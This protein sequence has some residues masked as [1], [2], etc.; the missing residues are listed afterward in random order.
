MR[1]H[2]TKGTIDLSTLP[3]GTYKIYHE[4][5][6]NGY[7]QREELKFYNDLAS[8]IVKVKQYS[9]SK[10]NGSSLMMTKEDSLTR[11][12]IGRLDSMTWN[13]GKLKV[14]GYGELAGLSMSSA[15]DV[16]H[17]LIIENWSSSWKQYSYTLTPKYSSWLAND[18]HNLGG[19]YTYGS[20]EGT[21][22]LSNLPWGTYRVY[23]QMTVNGYT[24]R[25]EL[26]FYD[27]IPTKTVNGYS[28]E[29][30][31]YNS[32]SVKLSKQIEK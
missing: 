12:Y 2:G 31:K 1:M 17:E 10:Y 15:S 7:K 14:S 28:Y 22:D 30:L 16:K 23:H 32:N 18:P 21:I 8:R 6:V 19:N 20:Y 26:K 5:T 24:Q 4:V 11:E 13:N 27:N 3:N 29:F 25:E 9:F